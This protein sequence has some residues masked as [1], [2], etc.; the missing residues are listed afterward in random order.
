MNELT[1]SKRNSANFEPTVASHAKSN[2]II[3]M[4]TSPRIAIV[5]NKNNRY[6]KFKVKRQSRQS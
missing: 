1:N 4:N 5:E 6:S 2:K 3:N